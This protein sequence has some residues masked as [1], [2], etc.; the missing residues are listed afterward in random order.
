LE[1]DQLCEV[2]LLMNNSHFECFLVSNRMD[3]GGR[4]VKATEIRTVEEQYSGRDRYGDLGWSALWGAGGDVNVWYDFE[5]KL[6][7]LSKFP[8][9]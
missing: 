5:T 6:C 1:H 2:E 7:S 4:L 9:L 8:W 3:F